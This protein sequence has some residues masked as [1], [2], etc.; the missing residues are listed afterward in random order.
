ML[1][2][3][4]KA[5]AELGSPLNRTLLQRLGSDGA[6]EVVDCVREVITNLED[7]IRATEY[8]QSEIHHELV[9]RRGEV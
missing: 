2:I 1:Q 4:H 8:S 9:T 6:T 5:S 7:T 3:L